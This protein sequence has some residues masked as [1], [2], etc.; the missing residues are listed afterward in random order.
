MGLMRKVK[1][2][3]EM[4]APNKITLNYCYSYYNFKA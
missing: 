1:N 4:G 2:Y 3:P